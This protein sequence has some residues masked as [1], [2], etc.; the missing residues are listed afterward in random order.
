MNAAD[1]AAIQQDGGGQ[2]AQFLIV[3][4]PFPPVLHAGGQKEKVV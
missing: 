4:V 1:T 2:S 3:T